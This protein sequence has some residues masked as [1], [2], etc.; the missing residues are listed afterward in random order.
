MKAKKKTLLGCYGGL[1]L[2]LAGTGGVLLDIHGEVVSVLAFT[3][4][5][6]EAEK[7]RGGRDMIVLSPE[8]KQGDVHAMWRRTVSVQHTIKEWLAKWTEPRCWVA[9]EDHAFGARGTSIYQL[10]HLHGLVRHGL[11]Q[12][13]MKW[14]LV[15]PT[16]LKAAVTGKGNADKNAM[17]QVPTPKLDQKSFGSS[18]RNNVVDAYWLARLMM[19]Y[20]ECQVDKGTL[21][22]VPGSFAKVLVPHAKRPG[23]LRRELLP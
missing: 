18:T 12:M 14:L 22:A 7:G 4:S 21:N 6:R 2:S 10:G 19:A 20:A 1:D 13:G 17:M 9:I 15:A 8:V 11:Q 3:T 5:K 16:E 23:L